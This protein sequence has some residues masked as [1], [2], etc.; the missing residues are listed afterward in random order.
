MPYRAESTPQVGR[1][2][3]PLPYIFFVKIFFFVL[4][5]IRPYKDMEVINNK[6]SAASIAV[7]KELFNQL[8]ACSHFIGGIP[9]KN[10]GWQITPLPYFILQ[11][12]DLL[13]FA[14]E[15]LEKEYSSKTPNK[16]LINSCDDMI[17]LLHKDKPK[18]IFV[19]LT[20]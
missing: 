6:L 14:T 11:E 8:K 4:S 17:R 1:V 20:A 12:Q 18:L 16:E 19:T 13:T 10:K 7:T 2:N 3:P 5:E 9:E 15:T